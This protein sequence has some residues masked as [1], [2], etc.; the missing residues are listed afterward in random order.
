MRIEDRDLTRYEQLDEL[1]FGSD[2]GALVWSYMLRIIGAVLFI[3]RQPRDA[4]FH[5]TGDATMAYRP[6][7]GP[8]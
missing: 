6:P 5:D 4:L 8:M 1:N 3:V 2:T 7:S